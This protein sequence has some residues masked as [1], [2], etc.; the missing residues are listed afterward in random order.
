[1]LLGGGLETLLVKPLHA[2]E[3]ADSPNPCMFI[4]LH[5]SGITVLDSY[6]HSLDRVLAGNPW[7]VQKGG[8]RG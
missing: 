5:S 3:F 7:H 2:G 1:M 8:V 6:V 4:L